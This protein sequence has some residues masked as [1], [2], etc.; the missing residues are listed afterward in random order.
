MAELGEALWFQFLGG[1]FSKPWVWS[2]PH[3]WGRGKSVDTTGFH[4]VSM[5]GHKTSPRFLRAQPTRNL[6]PMNGELLNNTMAG[7]QIHPKP[8]ADEPTEF[9][10][11][12]QQVIGTAVSLALAERSWLWA[13]TLLLGELRRFHAIW[14]V[15]ACTAMSVSHGKRRLELKE[16]VCVGGG[17]YSIHNR[18]VFTYTFK[19]ADRG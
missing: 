11:Q 15:S 18:E 14:E 3:E 16:N 13:L 8:G 2:K 19:F 4:Q 12:G 9:V 7:F 5:W 1:S 17:S 6:S 10:L